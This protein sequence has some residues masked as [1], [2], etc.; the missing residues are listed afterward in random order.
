MISRRSFLSRTTVGAASASLV[1]A[2]HIARSVEDLSQKTGQK[3][4]NIIHI[5]SDGMSVGTLTC[6]NLFSQQLRGHRLQWV[7]LYSDPAARMGMMITRSL[8]SLVTDSAAA[9]SSWGSGSHVANGAINALPNGRIL[10]PLYELFQQ[11]GWARGLV[12]T[13]EITHATPAGFASAVKSRDDAQAIAAQYLQRKVDVLLGG[14]RPHFDPTKRKD[15]RDLYRDFES[16]GYFLVRDAASLALAPTSGR[17]LGTFA[18]SH[19]PYTIDQRQDARL[20][21]K[22]PTLAAMTTAALER[23]QQHNHFILQVEGARVDHAAHNSD[24]AA[25]VHDQIALDEAIEVCLNFRRKNPDTLIV[26]TTDHGNSNLGLN[27]MGGGYG[28]SSQRFANLAQVRASFPEILGRIEKVA[29]KIKVPPMNGDAED[30]LDAAKLAAKAHAHEKEQDKDKEKEKEDDAK[31]NSGMKMKDALRVEPKAIVDIV[32]DTTGY[33]MSNRR[34]ALFAQVLAGQY[35][36]LYD[37]MNSPVSQLGQI[38][39]NRLG[40]GWT[41][42]SHTCDLVPIVAIGPGS[43]RFTGIVENIQVFKHYTQLAD[44]DFQNSSVPLIAD[45]DIDNAHEIERIDRYALA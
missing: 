38:M 39:A 2:P 29:E 11:Q 37:Q 9:S 28:E 13:A 18:D 4:R 1:A 42:N 25:A 12:T 17:L 6:A 27:G 35:Q 10:T 15:K 5:V 30:H 16:A 22:I 31:V 21:G 40:I 36:A 45:A 20:S 26:I 23:L 41:G 19:L 7:K 33:R 32:A 24:A 34:A 8:N 14:G 43:E 44:I 3:P